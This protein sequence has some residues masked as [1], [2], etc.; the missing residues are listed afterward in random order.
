LGGFVFVILFCCSKD[1]LEVFCKRR[2][3]VAIA[4]LVNKR[5]DSIADMLLLE[6]R[7]DSL[8]E[9]CERLENSLHD[10][11]VAAWPMVEGSN[12]F[13]D[14]WHIEAVCEHLE[15]AFWGQI[16]KLLINIPPRTSKTTIISIMFPAWVWAQRPST[17][18]LYS[19]YKQSV[20]WEHSRLCRL[21]IESPW[22]QERWGHLVKLSKDQ[23]TKGHF[24]TTALGHRIATSV[25]SGGTALGGDILVCDD[26][27]STDESKVTRE[28]TNDWVSRVWASRLNPGGLGVNIVVQQRTDAMDVS[29]YHMSKDSEWTKLILPMEFDPERKSKTVP[30]RSTNG[31]PWTDPRKKAGELLCPKYL[32]QETIRVRKVELGSYNYAGQYQQSPAPEEGGIF[33]K[34]LWKVWKF[35]KL[36]KITYVLQSWDTALT[37][38]ETSAY[39]ACTSWGIFKDEQ[40]VNN[41]ILLSAWR[42]RVSISE[43]FERAYRLRRNW[44]DIGDICIESNERLIVDRIVI[45]AKASGHS[46]IQD[47][48]EK[49]VPAHAFDPG[50]YGDKLQRALKASPYVETGLVWVLAKSPAFSELRADQAMVVDECALFPKGESNDIVDTTSQAI[51]ELARL[52]LLKHRMEYGFKSNKPYDARYQPGFLDKK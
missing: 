18:F 41:A 48:S 29:G 6:R 33:K 2:D 40:G 52:G 35:D 42:G 15:A 28:S 14:G 9:E 11:L 26:L 19:S 50:K 32:T 51:I 21:L 47:F 37:K 3:F 34:H 43:L 20:S 8:V 4:K 36:P 16:K 27:N 44:K 1:F 7:P 39:S 49:G 23:D 30:L 12:P 13:L 17:K 46:V 5:L 38:K 25:S 45:E 31:K 24:T 22:Y 10:F